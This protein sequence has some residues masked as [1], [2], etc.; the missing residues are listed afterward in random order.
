MPRW[1]P[2]A[3]QKHSQLM[4]DKVHEWQPWTKST[5]AR[6][7]HGK[8]RSSQNA[9]KHGG[10]ADDVQR[11]T[12]V[13]KA[14]CRANKPII[15]KLFRQKFPESGN[16]MFT[17]TV[18]EFCKRFGLKYQR[19]FHAHKLGKNKQ[20]TLLSPCL[21]PQGQAIQTGT[22]HQVQRLLVN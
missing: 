7:R 19:H 11:A 21:S 2:E 17:T 16:G 15:G 5:G 10:Y 6:T 18:Q 3:R 14:F 13:F 1:T 9:R 20:I 8:K 4:R 12:S 22:N